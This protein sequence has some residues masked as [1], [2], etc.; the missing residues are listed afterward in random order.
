MKRQSLPNP[1]G[2]HAGIFGRNDIV[3]D[4]VSHHE[5]LS[6]TA[7]GLLQRMLIKSDIRLG[8]PDLRGGEDG[9]DMLQQAVASGAALPFRRSDWR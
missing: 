2:M 4:P 7:A 6:G 9:F 3:V 1:Q 5:S 8:E